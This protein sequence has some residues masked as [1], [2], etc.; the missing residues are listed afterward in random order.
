MLDAVPILSDVQADVRAVEQPSLIQDGVCQDTPVPEFH[1]TVAHH[2]GSLHPIVFASTRNMG[3]AYFVAVTAS[4]RGTF[5]FADTL[6]QWIDQYQV[7]VR[8]FTLTHNRRRGHSKKVISFRGIENFET[9]K[10]EEW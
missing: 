7:V 10:R 9:W 2:Y 4:V 1:A 5:R 6:L 3:R 8:S